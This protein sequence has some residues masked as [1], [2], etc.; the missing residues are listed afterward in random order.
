MP[1]NKAL[2]KRYRAH[3]NVEICTSIGS[4]KYIF[5]YIYKGFDCADLKL[6]SDTETIINHDEILDFQDARYVSGPEACWRIF[7]FGM[8]ENSHTIERL[9]VHGENQKRVQFEPGNEEAALKSA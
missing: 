5:K 3:I 4:I 8:H 6:Q 7:K 1:Y 9:P 2:L